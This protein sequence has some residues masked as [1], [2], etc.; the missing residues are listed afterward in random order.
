MKH[1]CEKC[2]GFVADTVDDYDPFLGCEC[3][4]IH[5]GES[6]EGTDEEQ[7]ECIY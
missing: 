6:S 7:E 4:T 3:P 2:G 1:I 5:I